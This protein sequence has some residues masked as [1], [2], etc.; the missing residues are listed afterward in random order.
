[1]SGESPIDGVNPRA[2]SLVGVEKTSC[3]GVGPRF[4]RSGGLDGDASRKGVVD[5]LVKG[6]QRIERHLPDHVVHSSVKGAPP[7]GARGVDKAPETI[8]SGVFFAAQNPS[9]GG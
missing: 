8:S 2:S 4:Y 1:M 9:E 3:V 7:P 6:G 5:R